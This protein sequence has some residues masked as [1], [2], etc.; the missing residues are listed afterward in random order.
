MFSLTMLTPKGKIF[1]GEV[2]EMVFPTEKGP[3]QIATDYTPSIFAL[4]PYGVVS[5]SKEGKKRYYAVFSGAV[6]VEK[7]KTTLICEEIDDGYDIDMARAIAS[8]DRALDRIAKKESGID[9]IRAKSSLNRALA[10]I[11]AKN[12]TLGGA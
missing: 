2:D 12:R 9:I 11:D 8:R 6:W 10:R 4:S 7:E 3:T 1:E 5:L